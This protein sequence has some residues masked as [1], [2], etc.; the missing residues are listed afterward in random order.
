MVSIIY[1]VVDN[2]LHALQQILDT[3]TGAIRRNWEEWRG[4]DEGER[5][6]ERVGK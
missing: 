6:R 4:E 3:L 5:R 1:I 2:A